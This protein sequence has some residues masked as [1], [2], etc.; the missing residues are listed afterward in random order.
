MPGNIEDD[1]LV[2]GQP[3]KPQP[4]N[5]Y[6][7]M[8][9]QL[10]RLKFAEIGHRQIWAANNNQP[11]SP[12]SFILNLDGELRRAMMD[13]PPFYQ[14][15]QMQRGPTSANPEDQVQF[16]ERIMLNLAVHSRVLRLH[17]PWL[18]R[19]YTDESFAYSKEQCIRAARASLRMMGNHNESASFLEKWWLPLFYG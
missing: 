8:S 11:D 1:D 2:D 4:P 13:L 15:D 10:A 18:W 19:G 16:Y 17:R 5:V 3:F 9:F 6:T 14:P 7:R 12:Y